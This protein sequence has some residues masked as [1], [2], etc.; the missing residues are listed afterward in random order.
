MGPSSVAGIPQTGQWRVVDSLRWAWTRVPCER[1]LPC[2]GPRV[3][4]SR[5]NHGVSPVS[6]AVKSAV[7]SPTPFPEPPPPRKGVSWCHQDARPPAPCTEPPIRARP[8]RVGSLTPRIPPPR[9]TWVHSPSL[10]LVGAVGP[11]KARGPPAGTQL[12][13]GPGRAALCRPTGRHPQTLREMRAHRRE[14]SPNNDTAGLRGA[15]R[16]PRPWAFCGGW[17]LLGVWFLLF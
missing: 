17:R 8:G 1:R 3:S 4:P 5:H 10:R 13:L 9:S 7:L 2:P 14:S 16:P 12:L 6:A 15:P 11:A